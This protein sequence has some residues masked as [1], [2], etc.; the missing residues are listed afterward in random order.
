MIYR[1]LRKLATTYNTIPSRWVGYAKISAVPRTENTA[2]ESS[3]LPSAN[4]VKANP[5]DSCSI[6][7]LVPL[8]KIIFG[9]LKSRKRT[10]KVPQSG[11]QQFDQI[12]WVFS[13]IS[14]VYLFHSTFQDLTAKV[15]RN[16]STTTDQLRGEVDCRLYRFVWL[17]SRCK[18]SANSVVLGNYRG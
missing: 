7:R 11:W 18:I 2:L 5:N 17:P 1:F 6:S 8:L 16:M 4:A 3:W 9:E 13:Q 12:L 10:Q 14:V 15:G